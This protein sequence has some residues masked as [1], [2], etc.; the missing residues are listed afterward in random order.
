MAEILLVLWW[1]LWGEPEEPTE[2][3]EPRGP[4]QT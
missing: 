3:Q 1:L 4:P 2:D